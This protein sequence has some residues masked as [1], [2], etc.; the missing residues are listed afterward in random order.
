MLGLDFLA[1]QRLPTSYPSLSSL[2]SPA[3]PPYTPPSPPS[4]KCGAPELLKREGYSTPCEAAAQR[5][6]WAG[7]PVAFSQRNSQYFVPQLTT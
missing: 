2:C 7:L 5:D 4:Y 6:L 3:S 1:P